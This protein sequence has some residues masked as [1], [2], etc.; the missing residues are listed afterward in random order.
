MYDEDNKTVMVEVTFANQRKF[1]YEF[2]LKS[3]EDIGDVDILESK[4][5]FKSK[6]ILDFIK[7]DGVCD[8][9][10]ESII[11]KDRWT[12]V[13]KN[14]LIKH[15]SFFK[16]QIGKRMKLDFTSRISPETGDDSPIVD[17]IFGISSFS[18][19]LFSLYNI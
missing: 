3:R 15:L 14:F 7:N 11:F 19:V 12:S 5:K 10:K 6:E 16:C 2:T 1:E 17:T 8:F 9:A 13:R 4:L 18:Y